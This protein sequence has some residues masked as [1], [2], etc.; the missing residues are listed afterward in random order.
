MK[1]Y[2]TLL[3]LVMTFAL[4][5]AAKDIRTLYLTTKPKMSC[6]NCENKIKGNIRFVKGVKAIETN[7]E[8]QL[9]TVTYDADKTTEETIIKSF[10]K[11]GYT[12]ERVTSQPVSQ[13]ESSVCCQNQHNLDGEQ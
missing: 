5:T 3:M 4:T 10:E 7:I 2:F 6:S 8:K 13:K 1:K 11:F 12:A 9:V